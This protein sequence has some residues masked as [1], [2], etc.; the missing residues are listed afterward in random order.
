MISG[1]PHLAPQLAEQPTPLLQL[2]TLR[3][4]TGSTHISV[5]AKQYRSDRN[6]TTEG[7]QSASDHTPI[8]RSGHEA[9][10]ILIA[11]KAFLEGET[12]EETMMKWISCNQIN[13]PVKARNASES[14][15]AFFPIEITTLHKQFVSLVED[16]F[17]L[18]L[19]KNGFEP[20]EFY[21]V[22]KSTLKNDG[23]SAEPAKDVLKL[24]EG[25]IDFD[26]FCSMVNNGEQKSMVEAK[27]RAK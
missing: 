14:P 3:G 2:L 4:F 20:H 12:L 1:S 26:V 5:E 8:A 11:A 23:T 13:E 6:S 21:E 19:S 9:R 25:T 7:K 18:F 24:L 10:A 27:R 22:V 15:M 17:E 16:E